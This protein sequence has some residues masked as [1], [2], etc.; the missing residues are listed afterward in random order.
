MTTDD[1]ILIEHLLKLTSL[2]MGEK[3]HLLRLI[4][5]YIDNGASMCM[6]CDP[7]VVQA[8]RRLKMWWELYRDDFYRSIFIEKKTENDDHENNE[9]EKNKED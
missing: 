1:F 3:E 4:R 6:T 8:W 9:N 5:T 7:Q 2:T